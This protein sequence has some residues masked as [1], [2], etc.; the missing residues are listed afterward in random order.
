M[1]RSVKLYH[2]PATRS[3]RVKWVLH[4]TVGD[5][6][7]LELLDLYAGAQYEPDYLE[8]NPNHNVPLL[9]IEFEDGQTFL[10]RESAAMVAYFADAYP[11]KNIAPRPG[12]SRARADYLQ[13]LHF[14]ATTMDMMLWQ[15]RI[16]EHVLPRAERD[17]RTA[18]RYRAK[19]VSEVE[20]QLAER[21]QAHAF[22]CGEA[23][24]AADCVIGHDVAW[25]RGYGMCQDDLFK[26]YLSR[27]SKR[28]AFISAF[29]DARGFNPQPP[30]RPSGTKVFFNG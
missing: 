2:Y 12:G 27:L 8:K 19:F 30:E 24:T 26:A 11:E 9:E 6:F 20:P 4:E 10:M 13:M 7:T 29:A 1:I 15:V 23:F 25:A 3:A 14:G 28:R 17:E 5:A 22:I 21:L 16:H 18:A